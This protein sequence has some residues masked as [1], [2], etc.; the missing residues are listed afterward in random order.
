M[1]DNMWRIRVAVLWIA[2]AIAVTATFI[3]ALY[4]P[5]FLDEILLGRLEGMD[6]NMGVL[7]L[8]AFFWLVPL[9]MMYFS[10]VLKRS[11]LRWLNIVF[12][13][14]LGLMN[15]YDFI[16]QVTALEAVGMARA[17]MVALM[18][19]IPFMIAWHGWKWPG[20]NE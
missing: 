5:G 13:L 19:V 15:L 10:L 17:I 3:L 6:I 7:L 20:E 9:F 16:G 4:E 12:G 11:A 18:A 2:D 1:T 14:L 8:A